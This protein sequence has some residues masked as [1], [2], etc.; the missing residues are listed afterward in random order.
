MIL[1]FIHVDDFMEGFGEELGE[2]VDDWDLVW[3]NDKLVFNA[4]LSELKS[5]SFLV[6]VVFI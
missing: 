4:Q 1:T 2:E 3:L 5:Y 6:D